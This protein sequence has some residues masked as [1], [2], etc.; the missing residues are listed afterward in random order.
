MIA[1]AG[2]REGRRSRSP[3]VGL[4]PDKSVHLLVVEPRWFDW[5]DL[6]KPMGNAGPGSEEVRHDGVIS[7]IMSSAQ[8]RPDEVNWKQ[9][10]CRF[11]VPSL[12]EPS[13]PEYRPVVAPSADSDETIAIVW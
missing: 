8:A 3:D 1:D 5:R 2:P 12:K 7:P 13:V 9:S 4:P 11:F 6:T 10:A